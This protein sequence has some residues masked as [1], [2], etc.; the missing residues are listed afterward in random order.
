MKKTKEENL[1]PIQEYE[2]L[3]GGSPSRGI[4]SP[5]VP[6]TELAVF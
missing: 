3:S 2:A 6:I 4:T 1:I 5:W